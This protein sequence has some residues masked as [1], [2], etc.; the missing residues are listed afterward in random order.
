MK[1]SFNVFCI[2]Y[3]ILKVGGGTEV[4]ERLSFAW[5]NMIEKVMTD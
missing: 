3:N 4:Q 1:G 5:A 2:L